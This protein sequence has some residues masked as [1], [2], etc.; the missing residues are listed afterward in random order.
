MFQT[1]IKRMARGAVGI[2]ALVATA[3]V[4]MALAATSASADPTTPALASHYPVH[5]SV[6]VATLHKVNKTSEQGCSHPTGLFNGSWYCGG[7]KVNTSETFN[8]MQY[9]VS[10]T[11]V[12]GCTYPVGQY[13]G[14]WYCG[15][16]VSTT[17][18][19]TGRR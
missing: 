13:K 11:R 18:A 2:V 5:P 6:Y 8:A 7:Y 15:A 19:I 4:P 12:Q 9:I 14:V 16:Y 10:K 17:G 3:F 1:S